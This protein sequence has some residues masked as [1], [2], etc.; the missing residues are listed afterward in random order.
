M[1][2]P[3]SAAEHL[4]KSLDFVETG[5]LVLQAERWERATS[6]AYYA[7]FHT[8]QALLATVGVAAETHAD[9]LSQ[10]ALHFV[11]D[12]PLPE[13]SSRLL[14]LLQN[15]RLLADYGVR[16]EITRGTALADARE[17]AALLGAM[18]D[19]L[20]A[21]EA[22]GARRLRAAAAELAAAARALSPG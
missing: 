6:C 3:G 12:G 4:T 21:H 19:Q 2:R 18:L 11:K 15:D 5:L 20:D 9:V 14:S 7:V 10:V 13:G 17:A 16:R 22:E 8:A 1:V